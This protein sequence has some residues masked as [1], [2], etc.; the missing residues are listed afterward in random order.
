M[1]YGDLFANSVLYFPLNNSYTYTTT[2]TLR[3]LAY[4]IGTPVFENDA[5]TGLGS[6][7]S[8][9]LNQ[10]GGDR[11]P[12]YEFSNFGSTGQ[13]GKTMSFWIKLKTLTTPVSGSTSWGASATVLG[14]DRKNDLA[15]YND[16]INLGN[17]TYNIA[18]S[19]NGSLTDR[20]IQMSTRQVTVSTSTLNLSQTYPYRKL[21][22]DQWVHVAVV[23]KN[24]STLDIAE[25]A[26]YIDGQCVYYAIVTNTEL[27]SETFATT[28][29]DFFAI[30]S[31]QGTST[32]QTKLLSHYGLFNYPMTKEQVRE[33]AWYGHSNEDYAAVVNSDNPVYFTLFDNA[34]KTI[35]PTV[36]G[37]NAATWGPIPDDNP[38]TQVTVNNNGLLP[39]KSWQFPSTSTAT[40]NYTRTTDADAMSG[41]ASL[42]R[43]GEFSIEMWVKL[44]DKPTS[45]RTISNTGNTT[46]LD[47]YFDLSFTS[48]GR[49][50]YSG[51]YKNGASSATSGSVGSIF[52]TPTTGQE[53]L[54]IGPG[55]NVKGFADNEWHHVVITNTISE[56]SLISGT[57]GQYLGTVYIDGCRTETRSWTTTYGWPNGTNP[58]TFLQLGSTSTTTTLRNMDISALAFFNRRLTT[59]EIKEH[60]VAGLD[61]T[62]TIPRTVKYYDG[63]DWVTSSGQKVWNGSAW[64]DWDSKYWNGSAWIAF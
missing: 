48:A 49:I 63:A 16:T 41:L 9:V 20:F 22:L 44:A 31:P 60:F 15:S 19:P 14:E 27:I 25:K 29:S 12:R 57:A 45:T 8:F 10:Y 36:S 23:W 26:I 52:P 32:T 2:G 17:G 59:Q 21:P 50:V 4:D 38:G 43:S 6:T 56:S 55:T 62:A 54:T 58:F 64:I 28:T 46:L 37:T 51:A 34:D 35:D 30:F 3:S 40:N 7:H 11:P 18:E 61:Y 5:P 39:F 47:G 1:A 13:T 42:Y 53:A 24:H 33:L